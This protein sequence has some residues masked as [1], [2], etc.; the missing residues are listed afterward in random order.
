MTWTELVCWPFATPTHFFL[1][2]F[3]M[4]CVYLKALP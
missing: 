1:I 3:V 2:L 4:G